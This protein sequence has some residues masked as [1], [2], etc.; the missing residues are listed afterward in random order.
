MN[1]QGGGCAAGTGPGA[2]LRGGGCAAGP[3][4]GLRGGGAPPG[5]GRGRGRAAGTGPGAGARRR[6]GAGGGAAGPPGRGRGTLGRQDGAIVPGPGRRRTRMLVMLQLMHPGSAVVPMSTPH[7]HSAADLALAPVL[8]SLERNL[9]R[10]RTCDNLDFA[11]ALDLNDDDRWYHNPAE[12]AHRVQQSALRDVDLH[13][14]TVAPTPDR[15]GLAVSHGGYTVPVMLG[16]RLTS[17][18]KHGLAAAEVSGP[19]IISGAAN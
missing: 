4:A 11:L 2:G 3:G 6:D 14:W 5:R 1:E 18:I 7:P 13:G 8:I 10:L 16:E 19:T 15:H 12:R 9:A 17:Y